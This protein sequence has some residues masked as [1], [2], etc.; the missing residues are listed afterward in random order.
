MR[1]RHAAIEK[2]APSRAMSALPPFTSHFAALAPGYDVVLSDVWGVV[3]NG[4]AAT[5]EAC[6]ALARFRGA[7]GTV[8]LITNAP[9]PGEV[10]VRTMLDRLKV[11]RA[12]YDGIISSGDVTR[13]L[14]AAR[15][16][17]RV[18]HIGPPR[19]LPIFEGLDAPRDAVGERRLRGLLRPASTT[20][21]RR[22]RITAIS[23]SACGRAA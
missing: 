23:S 12:A 10:V 17:E 8:V 15:G 1:G 22:R 11:P 13:A 20:P 16:S 2:P 9:R 19:D 18:F 14:I 7:G 6:D 4:V 5:P 3:H 21:S